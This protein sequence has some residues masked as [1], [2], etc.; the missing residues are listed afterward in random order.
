MLNCVHLNS[1]DRN[2]IALTFWHSGSVPPTLPRIAF[3]LLKSFVFQGLIDRNG[4]HETCTSA[5]LKIFGRE[6]SHLQIRMRWILHGDQ[7]LEWN[8]IEVSFWSSVLTSTWVLTKMKKVPERY[9][10][11]ISMLK[12]YSTCAIDFSSPACVF[13]DAFYL[14]LLLSL[15]LSDKK[16][17]LC[18]W[19]NANACAVVFGTCP[20][21]TML[22]TRISIWRWKSL[23][24]R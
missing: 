18:K 14:S 1:L 8:R 3:F 6:S 10:S 20:L 5:A 9:Y 7:V 21:W 16:M 22:C 15:S 4:R 24:R 23:S 2:D 12:I 17:R 13:T 19:E 11:G